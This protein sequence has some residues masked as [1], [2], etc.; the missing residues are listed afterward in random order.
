V[1]L[2]AMADIVRFVVTDVTAIVIPNTG[3]WLMEE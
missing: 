1:P 2:S 3:H